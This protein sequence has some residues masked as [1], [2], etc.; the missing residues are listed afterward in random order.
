[1]TRGGI[2]TVTRGGSQRT[3]RVVGGGYWT[4]AS[5]CSRVGGTW[6]VICPGDNSLSRKTAPPPPPTTITLSRCA[7]AAV[8]AAVAAAAARSTG[9]T[10]VR[11]GKPR[12]PSR[13]RRNRVAVRPLERYTLHTTVRPSSVATV[14][15]ETHYLVF[16]SGVHTSIAQ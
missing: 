12:R 2:T 1:M 8:A 9:V 15:D 10:A 4:D 13:R 6:G 5:M 7:D 16:T 14:D 11:V 3:L